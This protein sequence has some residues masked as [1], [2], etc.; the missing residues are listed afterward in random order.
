M[1]PTPL[2]HSKMHVFRVWNPRTNEVYATPGASTAALAQRTVEATAARFPDALVQV[3][4]A[5]QW[6]PWLRLTGG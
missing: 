6:H 3:Y 1:N 2:P 4:R 5:G